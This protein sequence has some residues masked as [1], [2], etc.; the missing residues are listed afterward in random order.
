VLFALT[1]A[2]FLAVAGYGVFGPDRGRPN[3]EAVAIVDLRMAFVIRLA[4][5]GFFLIALFWLG[6]PSSVPMLLVI[7]LVMLA[8]EVPLAVLTE[9]RHAGAALRRPPIREPLAE[10]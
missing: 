6:L 2:A 1:F 4:I 7:A 3:G 9:R 5:H 8:T 10:T